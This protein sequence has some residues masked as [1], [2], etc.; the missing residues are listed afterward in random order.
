[1]SEYEDQRFEGNWGVDESSEKEWRRFTGRL[2]DR[3]SYSSPG[4]EIKLVPKFVP[5]GAAYRAI[6]LRSTVDET[7]IC[8]AYGLNSPPHPWRT[9]GVDNIH[10]LEDE[11]AWVDRVVSTVVAEIRGAW[12]LPHP[13]FLD[14]WDPDQRDAETVR[15][16]GDFVMPQVAGNLPTLV[17]AVHEALSTRFDGVEPLFSGNGFYVPFGVGS[18]GYVHV[19]GVD[20]VRVHACIV[21]RV[22]GRTRAAELIGDLSRKHPRFK[23][24]L[25]DDTVHVA[26]GVDA[27]PFVPQHVIN[28]AMRISR[29]AFA[30]DDA[31]AETF[32]GV[33]HR[34]CDSI[35]MHDAPDSAE[36]VDIPTELMTLL[37]M[38]AESGGAIDADDVVK[39]CGADRSAMKRYETFCAEQAE[40]WREHAQEARLRD[41]HDA[42]EEAEAEA[43]PWDR[44]VRALQA[45]QR[46][47]GF[48]DNA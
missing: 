11:A 47:V 4:S 39:V 21:D 12:D 30:V 28:A 45:A 43:I 26:V 24:L 35:D 48:F 23:F 17:D 7:V 44:V 1:M 9:S 8:A 36:S 25:V 5:Q 40:S 13:S 42:A 2:A 18:A 19:A 46:T 6:L 38:D 10:I 27:T 32:G 37:E 3:L 29:F 15:S 34:E 31:F 33:V 16:A 14:D 41:E 22:S 20:E